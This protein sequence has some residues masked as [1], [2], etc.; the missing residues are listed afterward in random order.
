MPLQ[1]WCLARFLSEGNN[2]KSRWL[3]LL[4]KTSICELRCNSLDI[5]VPVEA[6]IF[7][8]RYHMNFA[9]SYKWASWGRDL[10]GVGGSMLRQWNCAICSSL[11]D[12]VKRINTLALHYPWRLLESYDKVVT[13]YRWIL[14]QEFLECHLI[15]DPRGNLYPPLRKTGCQISSAHWECYKSF[16]GEWLWRCVYN[17]LPSLM[18]TYYW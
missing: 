14:L 10:K 13:R 8:C 15:G 5:C 12:E 1:H 4:I 7:T 18:H 6:L 2:T 17:V 9:W 11:Q 16:K 3:S